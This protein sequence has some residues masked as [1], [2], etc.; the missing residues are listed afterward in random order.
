MRYPSLSGEL[1]KPRLAKIHQTKILLQGQINV[2]SE[3]DTVEDRQRSGRPSTITEEKV[4]EVR[5]I[6]ESKLNS[7]V[8]T[9]VTA[10]SIPRTT[11]HRTMTEYL[12]LKSYKAQFVQ[13]IY[14]EDMQDQ[15]EMCHTLIQILQDGNI[16][17]D[18]FF[19]R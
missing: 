10:C 5:E 15:T 4:D 9:V 7:S 11:A 3:T 6:C 14:E 18:I 13:E 17:D 8:R 12:P 19:Y 16:Q 2:F 1:Y